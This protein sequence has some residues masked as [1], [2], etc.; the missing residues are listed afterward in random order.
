MAND[1]HHVLWCFAKGDSVAFHVPALGKTSIGEVK[2]LVWE[3]EKMAYSAIR[4]VHGPASSGKYRKNLEGLE[5]L[6][7]K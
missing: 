1:I 3:R 5:G 2:C 6:F 4:A 7:V